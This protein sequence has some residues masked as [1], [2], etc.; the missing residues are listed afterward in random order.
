MP[1]ASKTNEEKDENNDTKERTSAND[2]FT[3]SQPVGKLLF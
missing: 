3:D 1:E 2:R